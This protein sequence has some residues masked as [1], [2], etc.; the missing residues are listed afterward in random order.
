MNKKQNKKKPFVLGFK[1]EKVDVLL[2]NEPS[3]NNLNCPITV[4][5]PRV[6]SSVSLDP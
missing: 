5:R 6:S 3:A 1:T 4:F 2:V